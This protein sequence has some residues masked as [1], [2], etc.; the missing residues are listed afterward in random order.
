MRPVAVRIL[1]PDPGPGAGPLERWVAASRLALAERH[2]AAFAAFAGVDARIVSGPPDDT[3]FG[4]RLR[5]LVRADRPAGGL[6]VLGSGAIPLA[7]AGDRAAFVS[8]AA[9]GDRR[10]LANNRYSA[11]IVAI[12]CASDGLSTLPDLPGDNALPRWL[13]ETAG[14]AVTDLRRR[15]RLGIDIDGPIDLVIIGAR[16]TTQ[17]RA[18]TELAA[19]NAIDL[20][21]VTKRLAALRSIA[22]DRHGELMVAGRTSATTLAW[23]EADTASRTRALVE[24]RGM[25]TRIGAQR[26][27]ASVL[28]ALLE[29]DGPQKLGAIVARFADGAIIDSRVLM[30]HRFGAD[31][32]GWPVAEDR[33]ASDLLLADRI[34]DPWL[35]ALTASA[36]EAPIPIVLGGHT[37]VGPGIRFVLGARAT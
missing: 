30:A 28:G 22:S 23:L 15:W 9:A 6:V 8:A 31:E 24:E 36:A 35:R 19:A 10:A 37:L 29:R 27:A 4:R 32:G 26:P 13:E 17:A 33:Y 1:H 12:A 34:G 14:Y 3:P 16:D 11:D 20:A 7:T 2:R 5:D 18:S 25:R 21:P